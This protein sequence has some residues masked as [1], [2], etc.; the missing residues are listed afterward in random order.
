ML[1]F[2]DPQ[3]D[4]LRHNIRRPR[5]GSAGAFVPELAVRDRPAAPRIAEAAGRAFD[6][7]PVAAT[8]DIATYAR[9]ASAKGPGEKPK[10]LYLRGA[11]AK[12]QAG[13]ILP[14]QD[15]SPKGDHDPKKRDPVFAKD[16]GPKGKDS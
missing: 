3:V 6:A 12:P 4:V 5:I 8:A 13:F 16:H 10:P 1:R 14:R 2:A 15:N 7:G 11:D 9:L